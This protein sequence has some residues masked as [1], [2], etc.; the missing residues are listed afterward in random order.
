MKIFPAIVIGVVAVAVITGFFI[1]GS[2]VTER[3]RRFDERRVSDLQTIQWEV[4]NYWQKKNQLPVALSDLRDDIRGFVPPQ[5]PETA[6]PYE[7]AVNGANSLNVV[8][9]FSLCSTFVMAGGTTAQ[10]QNDNWAH[11]AGRTCFTRTIDKDLYPPVGAK[12]MP[13]IQ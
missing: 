4:I 1:V 2:P 6:L 11:G 8:N 10:I 3:V 13:V 7:Y 12:I 5:D 9:S